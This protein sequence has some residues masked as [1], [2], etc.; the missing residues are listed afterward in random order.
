MKYVA[1]EEI[2]ASS[3]KEEKPSKEETFNELSAEPETR[4]EIEQV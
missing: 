2:Q 3:V 1:K 4:E